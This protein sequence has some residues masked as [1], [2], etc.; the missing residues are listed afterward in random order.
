VISEEEKARVAAMPASALL[1]EV[2]S[3]GAR[4]SKRAAAA[5]GAP[6]YHGVGWVKANQKY[7]ARLVTNGS[8]VFIGYYTYAKDAA[9]AYDAAAHEA[10]GA[11]AP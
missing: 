4:A 2:A 11:C 6:V 7:R 9:K 1:A 5:G 3:G 10:F 8:S